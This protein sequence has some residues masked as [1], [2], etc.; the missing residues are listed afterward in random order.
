[1]MGIASLSRWELETNPPPRVLFF[2]SPV[3]LFPGL[4]PFVD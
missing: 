4:P 1:M 2:D 3:S